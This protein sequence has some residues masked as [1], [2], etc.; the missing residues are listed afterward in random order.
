[1][2]HDDKILDI[3]RAAD[4]VR[5]SELPT[6]DLD[7]FSQ[8]LNFA[9]LEQRRR[10]RNRK[11][12]IALIAGA[13]AAVLVAVPVVAPHLSSDRG[14]LKTSAGPWLPNAAAAELDA[15][16]S[17]VVVTPLGN[18]YAYWSEHE[19]ALNG[20]YQNG[21]DTPTLFWVSRTIE[22]WVGD[23]C[24]NKQV[25]TWQPYQFL[26]PTD[27]EAWNAW[28]DQPAVDAA[29]KAAVQGG[30]RTWTG[31]EL[32]PSA[33]TGQP[34]NPCRRGGSY[35]EPTPAYT[36]SLP[37]EPQA[38]I[39]R[40][41]SDAG[42]LAIKDPDSVAGVLLN[43][44]GQPWLTQVQRATALEAL[45]LVAQRYVVTEKLEVAGYPA[46]RLSLESHGMRSDLLVVATTPSVWE[47]SNTIV[48][49]AAA[50]EARPDLA[51][52][53]NGTVIASNKVTLAAIV[54]DM[55]TK[56]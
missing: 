54:P 35:S 22:Y 7:A 13:A 15:L 37:T 48:D 56:P 32:W 50:V 53:P 2:N 36:E 28:A 12:R 25:E 8:E 29:D 33:P 30:A 45:G 19:V 38:L 51:G 27:R 39:D 34:A 16:A 41:I 11:I 52:L 21:G 23:S 40:L 42:P 9:N 4:P 26:T 31:A 43:V 47:Q 10:A 5:E 14:G 55:G 6:L 20:S 24:N 46:I 1:M 44:L 49:S 17:K 3:L 18:R